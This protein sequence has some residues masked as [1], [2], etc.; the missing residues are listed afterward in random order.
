[1]KL[2]EEMTKEEL[3]EYIE[4]VVS[5][6]FHNAIYIGGTPYYNAPVDIINQIKNYSRN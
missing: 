6:Y 1:M 5:T 3:Q 2:P 4:N